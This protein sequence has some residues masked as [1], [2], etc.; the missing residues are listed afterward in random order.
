MKTL[1]FNDSTTL[2]IDFR[3]SGGDPGEVL[4]GM[5]MVLVSPRGAPGSSRG[6][7]GRAR[8]FQKNPRGARRAPGKPQEHQGSAR[9]APREPQGSP[10]GPPGSLGMHQ[11]SP[12]G[13]PGKLQGSPKSPKKAPRLPGEPQGEAQD[14]RLHGRRVVKGRW[15]GSP[16][17]AVYNKLNSLKLIYIYKPDITY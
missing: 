1:I 17:R 10:R 3:R 4:G 15:R 9:E 5:G 14:F 6:A 2:F 11:G 13:A 16:P 7:P 12:K 8:G